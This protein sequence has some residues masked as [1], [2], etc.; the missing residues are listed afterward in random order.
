[1]Y[2]GI[3]TFLGRTAVLDTG[4]AQIVVTERAHEPMDVGV[5]THCGIDP[6]RLSL[7]QTEHKAIA[8]GIAA[9]DADR[10]A[11]AMRAHIDKVT[12]ELLAF[13]REAPE[14]FADAERFTDDTLP[15]G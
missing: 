4:R 9:G 13:A 2:T 7:T 12:G 3:R 15:F 5:F 6:R 8:D 11:A 10:A 14:L 1:M